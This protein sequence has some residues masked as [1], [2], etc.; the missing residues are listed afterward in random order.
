MR[1]PLGQ[2]AERLCRNGEVQEFIQGLIH[3]HGVPPGA[4]IAATKDPQQS[5]EAFVGDVFTDGRVRALTLKEAIQ[6]CFDSAIYENMASH[7]SPGNV[8]R[9]AALECFVRSRGAEADS[10]I[11]DALV[12]NDNTGMIPKDSEMADPQFRQRIHDTAV[13]R[14]EERPW[15]RRR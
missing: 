15:L 12:Y 4:I 10:L 11:R 3:E 8:L 13:P 14:S 6:M 7:I 2:F 9:S 1:A 5:D